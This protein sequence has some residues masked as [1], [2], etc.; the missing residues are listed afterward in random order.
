MSLAP[1]S[2]SSPSTYSAIALEGEPHPAYVFGRYAI[3]PLLAKIQA[4]V[5]FALQLS[6]AFAAPLPSRGIEKTGDLHK[7]IE[8]LMNRLHH[9]N[10]EKATQLLRFQE[11]K[12]EMQKNI[13]Q[14]HA[15]QKEKHAV[16]K[17]TDKIQRE[18]QKLIK[19]DAGRYPKLMELDQRSQAA[20]KHAAALFLRLTKVSSTASR[21]KND[22]RATTETIAQLSQEIFRLKVKIRETKRQTL[23]L[24]DEL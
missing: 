14:A 10:D 1:F 11:I 9:L 6:G 21:L 3:K 7:Q 12:N 16:K 4:C 23:L 2:I 24:R 19:D 18:L 13:A 5:Y 17:E 15:L 22:F 8:D 20:D